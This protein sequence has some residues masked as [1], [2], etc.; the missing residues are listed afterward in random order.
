MTIA[1][2]L[3]KNAGKKYALY[4][5]IGALNKLVI[6]GTVAYQRCGTSADMWTLSDGSIIM[7]DDKSG[8]LRSLHGGT[9][10]S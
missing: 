6:E 8:K 2:N 1:E 5:I 9:N 4:S 7:C 3:I 10:E